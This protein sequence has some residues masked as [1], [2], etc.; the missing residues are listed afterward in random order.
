MSEPQ[1]QTVRAAAFIAAAVVAVAVQRLAPHA[2]RRGSW[3][4]NAGLWLIN[5]V[6]V[7]AVCGGCAF[8]VAAWAAGASIG[9]LNATHADLWFA[10]PTAVVGLDLVSYGWHR[11]NHRVPFLWRMH[12]VHHSDPSFTVSTGV[13]FHPAELVLALPVRLAAVVLLG[14][15]VVGVLVFEAVFTLANLLEHGDINVP[16]AVEPVLGHVVVTPALHRRHHTKLGSDRDSNFGT[17]FVVWDRVF[18]TYRASDST[19]QIETGL[20]GL[21]GDVPLGRALMLP[22]QR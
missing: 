16:R 2:R 13:R 15:P 17:I 4:V 10:V 8:T 21:A 3:Q 6:V 14:A 5:G 22:L 11:A 7:G 20:A 9:L 18:A 12:R 1:L 19:R